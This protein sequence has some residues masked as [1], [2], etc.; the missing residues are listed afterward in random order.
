[1]GSPL[2]TYVSLILPLGCI[3]HRDLVKSTLQGTFS[4]Q[5]RLIQVICRFS[6]RI[7][8]IKR[9]YSPGQGVTMRGWGW[10]FAKSISNNFHSH[11]GKC[12]ITINQKHLGGRTNFPRMG[13]EKRAD[14][15]DARDDK[16]NNFSQNQN[17]LLV[18]YLA[19]PL[20]KFKRFPSNG[21]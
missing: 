10:N 20:K 13:F 19:L 18:G 16:F 9:E 8:P 17:Y 14:H 6:K 1:M 12:K 5:Y 7:E 3:L 15:G 11:S 4:Q 21:F 2:G